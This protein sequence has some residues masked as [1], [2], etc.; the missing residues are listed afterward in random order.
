[1]DQRYYLIT[2]TVV[3]SSQNNET[4]FHQWKESHRVDNQRHYTKEVVRVLDPA[5]KCAGEHIQGRSSHVPI[6]HTQ[7]L[8]CQV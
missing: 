3:V 1:M 7:A 6:N 4:I 8:K 5:S 2:V